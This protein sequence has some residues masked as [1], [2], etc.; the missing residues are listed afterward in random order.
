MNPS[1]QPSAAP[2]KTAENGVDDDTTTTTDAQ[3]G[4]DDNGD[5]TFE[6]MEFATSTTGI[7]SII[8]IGVLL[9][10]I[11]AVSVFL[12]LK[13]SKKQSAF[14]TNAESMDKSTEMETPRKNRTDTLDVTHNDD[15]KEDEYVTPGGDDDV[16]EVNLELMEHNGVKQDLVTNNDDDEKEG[17]YVTKGGPETNETNDSDDDV[18]DGN[19][20]MGAMDVVETNDSDDDVLVGVDTMQ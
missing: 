11:L 9:L 3:Q 2:I 18:I 17:E 8:G 10:C 20:T 6:L 15:E 16:N 1:I 12:C 5:D 4:N 19:E 7:L 13:K 14:E